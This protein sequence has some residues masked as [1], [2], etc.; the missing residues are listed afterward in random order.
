M[1]IRI[2]LSISQTS[3]VGL[4]GVFACL[5]SLNNILD[6][7]SNFEFVRHVLSMDTTFEGNKLM[8][9]AIETS[10][11]HHIAYAVII[12][13]EAAIGLI[14]MVAAGLMI[15]A[16]YAKDSMRFTRA[17]GLAIVGLTIGFILWFGGFMIVGAEWFLMWQSPSWNGQ[18]AAFRFSSI[19]LGSLIF[20][21]VSKGI[22]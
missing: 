8:N 11:V 19:I 17:K 3:C 2:A 18:T 1:N 20:L 9:R 22:D 16:I 12:F 13:L 5:V 21:S 6:Y 14:N 4:I 15:S 10:Y 7:Q